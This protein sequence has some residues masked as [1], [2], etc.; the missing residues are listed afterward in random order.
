MGTRHQIALESFLKRCI[1]QVSGK[2]IPPPI[3]G[4]PD[5]DLQNTHED[6][7]IWHR[8][9]FIDSKDVLNVSFKL[10]NDGEAIK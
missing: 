5:L 2:V 1:L 4:L 6:A 9:I 3:S 7:S 10:G 8:G